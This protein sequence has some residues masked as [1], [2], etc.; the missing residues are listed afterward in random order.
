MIDG[1][2][3][4]LVQADIDQDI[5]KV[6]GLHFR[7]D[8]FGSFMMNGSLHKYFNN[9]RSNSNDYQYTD[10]VETLKRLGDELAINPKITQI[11]RVEFGV[12]LILP[13][14]AN[15]VTDSVVLFRNAVGETDCLGR[16]FNYTDYQ[17]K[18]Y[19]K[20]AKILRVEVKIKNLRH[21]RQKNIYIRTLDDLLKKNVLDGLKKILIQT[22]VDCLIIYVPANKVA[23]LNDA[24]GRRYAE[25]TNPLYW[26]K[27]RRDKTK[28]FSR[29]KKRCDKFINSIGENDLKDELMK[30]ICEK[31]NYLLNYSDMKSVEFFK[32]TVEYINEKA[33]SFSSLDN[34]MQN[35]TI[36]TQD[37]AIRCAGCGVIIENPSKGQ[38]FCSAKVVGYVNA[39]RC[40]NRVSNPHNHAKASIKRVLSIPLFFDMRDM[41]DKE[42]RKY[43]DAI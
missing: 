18:I 13:I 29:E 10:L 7:R 41:I 33:S 25:Y 8:K 24:D 1:V 36:S 35:S 21:L 39:H 40:R 38:K 9:G 22:F 30:Q 17:L 32:E 31:C 5:A 4:Y 3:A 20:D 15:I 43:L 42:K 14:N 28:N 16:S 37:N 19:C 2:R 26:N 23:K 34:S 12:N 27:I 6:N 11:S